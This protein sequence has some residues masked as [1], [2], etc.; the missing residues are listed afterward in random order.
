MIDSYTAR[1]S[2]PKFVG[3]LFLDVAKSMDQ[4][5]GE[6]TRSCA[7]IEAGLQENSASIPAAIG[8]AGRELYSQKTKSLFSSVHDR[9]SRYPI[10]LKETERYY[11]E[12]HPDRTAIC[13]AMQVYS[14]ILDRCNL[15]RSLRETDIEVLSS[16]IRG[17]PDQ[18]RLQ[19]SDPTLTLKAQICTVEADGTFVVDSSK[20]HEVLLLYPS[21]LIFLSACPDSPKVYQFQMHVPMPN[22]AVT[23]PPTNNSVITIKILGGTSSAEERN[24]NLS[25]TGPCTRDLFFSTVTEFIRNSKVRHSEGELDTSASLCNPTTA[26]TTVCVFSLEAPPTAEGGG[27]SRQRSATR[28]PKPSHVRRSGSCR[29]TGGGGGGGGGLEDDSAS[30]LASNPPH[31]FALRPSYSG[32]LCGPS[33]EAFEEAP[34]SRLAASQPPR[35]NTVAVTDITNLPGCRFLPHTVRARPLVKWPEDIVSLSNRQSTEGGS[36]FGS[37]G[38]S[39]LGGGAPASANLTH[40][41][42]DCT[43]PQSQCL[44]AG[45][46]AAAPHGLRSSARPLGGLGNRSSR[47]NS[48]GRPGPGG[49]GSAASAS[50]GK[51]RV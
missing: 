9:L 51:T 23:A 50:A 28:V 4:L 11:E 46:A 3:K 29:S 38:V 33:A 19:F 39:P 30:C 44:V 41:R 15:L 26:T 8:A 5:T 31:L 48:P 45:D 12:P 25:C 27:P 18:S 13:K 42:L 32:P 40:L 47:P 2:K 17:L 22:I 37:P 10:L 14:E 24:I 21:F 20:P 7:Y 35:T 16:E 34:A 43:P 1:L 36:A 49:D 6:Y